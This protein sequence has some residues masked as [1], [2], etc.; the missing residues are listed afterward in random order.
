M[1]WQG[2]VVDCHTVWKRWHSGLSNDKNIDS[3]AR[4]L[5]YTDLQTITL[6]KLY[7]GGSYG[8]AASHKSD[9]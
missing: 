7:H 6:T 2:L 8:G 9:I 3:L 4:M 5:H 1:L